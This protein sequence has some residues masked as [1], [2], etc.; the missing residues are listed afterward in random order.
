MHKLQ[1]SLI[2]MQIKLVHLTIRSFET[3]Q[4]HI[5]LYLFNVKLDNK[6]KNKNGSET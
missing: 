4:R 1:I 6:I 5:C 3:A 2:F